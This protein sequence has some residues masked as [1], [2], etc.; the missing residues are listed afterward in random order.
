MTKYIVDY[1]ASK[2]GWYS[3]STD[4]EYLKK[5]WLHNLISGDHY[6]RQLSEEAVK[7]YKGVISNRYQ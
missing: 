4:Y 3:I 7:L 6:I 5:T 1:V 2:T